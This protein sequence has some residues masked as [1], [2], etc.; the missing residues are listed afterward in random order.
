MTIDSPNGTVIRYVYMS[1]NSHTVK[2]TGSNETPPLSAQG[3]EKR[4]LTNPKQKSEKKST[5]P[6]R[7][8]SSSAKRKDSANGAPESRKKKVRN[9]ISEEE[10]QLLR[11]TQEIPNPAAQD[12]SKGSLNSSRG[13]RKWKKKS[14]SSTSTVATAVTDMHHQMNAQADLLDSL[15][16]ENLELMM[17]VEKSKLSSSEIP[18]GPPKIPEIALPIAPVNESD[19]DWS[20]SFE[21]P[22]QC[23]SLRKAARIAGALIGTIFKPG[24]GTWKGLVAADLACRAYDYIGPFFKKDFEPTTSQMSKHVI[25]K[26]EDMPDPR[27]DERA[28]R[29]LVQELKHNAKHQ[30]VAYEVR[31]PLWKFFPSHPHRQ[32]FVISA[33]VVSQIAT[34]ANIDFRTTPDDAFAR[35]TYAAKSLSTVNVS[36]WSVFDKEYPTQAATLV[37]Y[38]MHLQ[39]LQKLGCFPFPRPPAIDPYLLPG[40]RD[41]SSMVTDMMK[42]LCLGTL[43]LSLI[44]LYLRS[45]AIK[46]M[47][48]GPNTALLLWSHPVPTYKIM[49]CLT[50]IL[51]MLRL[52]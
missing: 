15:L 2:A 1:S 49:P 7:K 14:N 48:T 50:A 20:V 31:T 25:Y 35:L 52:W 36:R 29:N 37:G 22:S 10:R 45:E 17:E 4:E 30:K 42:F 9:G 27:I 51:M 16:E 11:K 38:A 18:T 33:E 19:L 13:S 43:S 23:V 32:E 6:R 41:I 3:S 21:A 5:Y 8:A 47:T 44:Q 34:S 26:V 12:S 46:R 28:D 40:N 24:W 39:M